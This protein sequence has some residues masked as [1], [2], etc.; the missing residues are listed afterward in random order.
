[1][2]A[3]VCDKH[4]NKIDFLDQFCCKTYRTSNFHSIK[5]DATFTTLLLPSL[6]VWCG[7]FF[8]VFLSKSR[9]FF[10][11]LPLHVLIDWGSLLCKPAYHQCWIKYLLQY[12]FQ[13]SPKGKT[14]PPLTWRPWSFFK[15]S[16]Q[17]KHQKPIIELRSRFQL[18]YI[19]CSASFFYQKFIHTNEAMSTAIWIT[20]CPCT[21]TVV[22]YS[23]V[24]KSHSNSCCRRRPS[25]N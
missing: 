18:D 4:V 17:L 16:L 3:C 9:I 11:W 24:Y 22:L 5:D 8:A 12:I 1:M 7:D 21:I 19:F 6:S 15:C 23:M 25:T 13:G 14:F 10:G 20:H 2:C